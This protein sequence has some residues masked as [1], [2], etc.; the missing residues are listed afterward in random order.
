VSYLYAT[1]PVRDD[2]TPPGRAD[3]QIMLM[4]AAV[5]AVRGEWATLSL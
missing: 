4:P 2:E 1:D 5:N 3:L